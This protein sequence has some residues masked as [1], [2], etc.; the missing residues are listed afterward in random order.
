MTA[1][2]D[3]VEVQ[4]FDG[5]STWL[6]YL[7]DANALR[8]DRGGE[9]AVTPS[10][11]A[12]ILTVTLVD[13]GDPVTDN[14][15]RPNRA[16][17]LRT[18]GRSEEQLT[19]WSE[20]TFQEIN[21]NGWAGSPGT[22]NYLIGPGMAVR[23]PAGQA[24]ALQRSFTGWAQGQRY[25]VEAE[26][27]AEY[28]GEQFDARVVVQGASAGAWTAVQHNAS[29]T[30][31]VR[32]PVF[33]P[34][35]TTLTVRLERG[36]AGGSAA[37]V[38]AS[39]VVSKVDTVDTNVNLF[40]GTI[41]DVAAR[42]SRD[43]RT[44]VNIVAADAVQDHANTMRYGATTGHPT[45]D[46][47]RWHARIARLAG[48][49]RT[50]VA[51]PADNA[52]RTFAASSRQDP[53][54]GWQLLGTTAGVYARPPVNSDGDLRVLQTINAGTRSLAQV[55]NATGLTRTLT[56]LTP[57]RVYAITARIRS[58]LSYDAPG[59]RPRMYALTVPGLG[60]STA[61][62]VSRRYAT[63]ATLTHTF[64][65]TDF[66][67]DL[68]LV[69]TE[70]LSRP[71]ETYLGGNPWDDLRLV[72]WSVTE[73]IPDDGISLSGVVY[74]SSLKN[75]FDLACDSV[76][77]YWW[78]DAEN[79]TQFRRRR[80]LTPIRATFSDVHVP[81]EDGVL[82]SSVEN[83]IENPDFQ[84]NTNGW[85]AG[86]LT[87]GTWGT[88]TRL[89]L[90]NGDIY[91]RRT[92][93]TP[94]SSTASPYFHLA[95]HV[96]TT[97]GKTYTGSADLR[98]PT[99]MS[100]RMRLWF[101][102]ASGSVIT[103]VTG[104]LVSLPDDG[105][106]RATVTATAPAGAVTMRLS[107]ITVPGDPGRANLASGDWLNIDHASLVEGTEPLN[108]TG[109][110]PTTTRHRYRWTG[111][112]DASTSIME[113]WTHTGAAD[114]LHVCYT[115]VDLTYDTRNVVN[116]LQ[117]TNHSRT[118][119][120]AD[121]TAVDTTWNAQDNGSIAVWGSRAAKVDT[122]LTGAG[123]NI[124]NRA[125]ALIAANNTPRIQARTIT[126]DGLEFP[127]ITTTLDVYERV[128]VQARTHAGT[129]RIVG[130]EHDLTLDKW[131]VTLRLS[132]EG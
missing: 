4:V 33:T 18:V 102:N 86:G 15:I 55:A 78:V 96:P 104:D 3:L 36:A 28:P 66:T 63:P 65:A 12:G 73:T 64:T 108:F 99:I 22:L 27:A 81:T 79:V 37:L 32:S 48:S 87:G 85:E 93:N 109:R 13:R 121:A 54:E 9:R 94:P 116:D 101:Y 1:P 75:H 119:G 111:A 38:V 16:V 35:A 132:L 113:T 115:D 97:P 92:L 21:S 128:G 59:I 83:L 98:S 103:S 34:G 31:T 69:R 120:A 41:Q 45:V 123:S 131:L 42:Y 20:H 8:V 74:E 10:I 107:T 117:V 19:T 29:G 30:T 89:A 114:P 53:A 17:R 77:A 80:D 122:S 11:D 90:P 50:P 72:D 62:T 5:G 91:A 26:V 2:I 126:F 88:H 60:S 125:N 7:C 46:A 70:S 76:G 105:W 71:S 106:Y 118:S 57:G 24:P 14:R 58:G 39:V 110:T 49:A 95:A 82:L 67:H 130:I 84:T 47:E 68:R 52:P 51:L 129:Y 40:K 23:A 127:R 112:A 100:H 56:G 43:G 6:P 44:F 124:M 61:A 25:V